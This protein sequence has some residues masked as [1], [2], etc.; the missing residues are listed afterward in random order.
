MTPRGILLVVGMLLLAARPA[1]AEPVKLSGGPA[2]KEETIAALEK[3]RGLMTVCWQRKPPATVKVTLA[4]A[5]SGEVTKATAKSKGPAAQCAAGILAVA[6]LAP[7]A[8]A[9]KGT[10]E[11]ETVAEGKANDVRAIHD[12]L[13]AVGTSFFAC[14]KKA[15]KFAGKITL[16]ITVAQDGTVTDASGS[17]DKG[18]EAVGACVAAAAK[19]LTLRP[20]SSPSVTYELGLTFQGGGADTA[21]GGAAEGVDPS[22][23]PSLKGPLLAGDVGPVIA[24]RR[25]A[26]QKCAKGKKARGK[27]VLRIAIGA[28]GKI[29]KVKIKSSEVGDAKIEDCLVKALDGLTFPAGSGE[30]VVHYPVRL[31]A[32]GLKTG[33]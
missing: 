14:Q 30:T 18:G 5:A 8:K 9:W 26:L 33:A 19:K 21:G 29:T 12:Q 2:D 32:D 1:A 16:R 22:L 28:D 13:A 20:I 10:V 24:G 27:V 25:A 11:L 15:P 6:T 7:A 23:Q 17:G 4:V 3:A 31:D